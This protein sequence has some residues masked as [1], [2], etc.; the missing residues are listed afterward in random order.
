MGGDVEVS[1]VPGAGSTFVL[2]LPAVADATTAIPAAR[3]GRTIDAAGD[4]LR[5]R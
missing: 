4:P 5:L 1:S 2:K 3:R